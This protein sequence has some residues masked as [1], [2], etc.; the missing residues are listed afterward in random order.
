MNPSQMLAVGLE[1][2][3]LGVSAAQ[4]RQMMEYLT[5]LQKWNQVHNLTAVK[6]VADMISL[7]LLDSLV[8]KPILDRPEYFASTL[9]DVGSGAGFPGIPLALV[10]PN[11]Q[12]T[13]M[14]ASQKKASF[15][16]QVKVT[17]GLENLTVVC[18]RVETYRTE[19]LFDLIISRAFSDLNWFIGASVQVCK[20]GGFWLAMKGQIPEQELDDLKREKQISPQEIIPLRVPDLA[21]QRHLLVFRHD[22][23]MMKQ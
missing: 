17:L 14:D 12:V 21:A 22:Q 18:G 23:A 2:A 7:H 19:R 15:M 20:P 9:L 11:L 6:D 5:L 16:R 8:V 3:G 10:S 4:Q 13:V 1:Q